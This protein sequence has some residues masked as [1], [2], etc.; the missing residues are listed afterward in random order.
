LSQTVEV[1]DKLLLVVI[2]FLK[3]EVSDDQVW[4]TS[5]W[6]GPRPT[7]T[8][9]FWTESSRTDFIGSTRSRGIS[10]TDWSGPSW[11][12]GP[13]GPVQ[14][15]VPIGPTDRTDRLDRSFCSM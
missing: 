10:R 1:A 15:Q 4:T 6:T 8:D 14:V 11:S 9:R 12:L 2:Y 7:E 5:V 13:I 3:K